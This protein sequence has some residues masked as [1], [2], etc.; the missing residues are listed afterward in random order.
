MSNL[1]SQVDLVE[2]AALHLLSHTLYDL[3]K[4]YG[5]PK[6]VAKIAEDLGLNSAIL[7]RE[8][9]E[10]DGSGDENFDGW[11]PLRLA[12]SA[13]YY[14]YTL[15]E[16]SAIR[17]AARTLCDTNEVAKNVLLHKRNFIVGSGVRID[18][19]PED[20]G[21][22]PVQLSKNKENAQIRKMK[23]NWKAFTKA[24]N[25]TMRLYEW[26]RRA[27]RD[28]EVYVRV[29]P[30]DVPQ[31][32]FLEPGFIES[33]D[34]D[35]EFGI[36]YNSVD[37]E[38]VEGVFYKP[39]SDEAKQ[40]DIS[41]LVIDKR[42]V[43]NNAPRGIS[44]FWPCM[45][46]F[47][48]LEKIL[49]NSSVLATVQAAITMVRSHDKATAPQVQNM[50]NRNSDGMGRIDA[51][52]GRAIAARKVRPGTVLDAPKGTT[53]TFPSHTVNA[54]SF[55]EIAKHELTHIANGFVLPV[56]WLLTTEPTDPLTPGSPVIA[57]F[58]TEQTM[59]FNGVEQ[60]FW[61][62]Q[63]LMGIN[64]EQ[65]R[66]KYALYFNGKR[67]AVGKALDEARVDAILLGLHATSP[68]EIAAKHGRNY[69]ITRSNQIKHR[70]TQQPGEA[71]PGD[72]GN[73]SPTSDPT[74]GG[75]GLTKRGGG[76]RGADGDGGNTQ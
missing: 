66:E 8:A 55:I 4:S 74:N 76:Q 46:N 24:N 18:I 59:L 22:D 2:E 3:S 43:D 67:L 14:D 63:G 30:G 21:E 49:V 47:R 75:D 32:R 71:M 5:D 57:N 11:L 73:T 36:K 37:V 40:I 34:S 72:A 6:L 68:Q 45:S 52:T 17:N 41:T 54:A 7:T 12:S 20:L 27:D 61:L 13:Q 53:Y 23:Q 64:V 31:I 1:P 44:S 15:Q 33:D 58:E 35:Y 62:I 38:I 70:A 26:Q 25:F 50:I 60:L 29:F 9:A 42:N 69:T 51:T 10:M 65:N 56:D 39:T 16:L 48:R 19:Y 28:G